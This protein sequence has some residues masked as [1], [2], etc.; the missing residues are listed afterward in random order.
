MVANLVSS[1]ETFL[2]HGTFSSNPGGF[3]VIINGITIHTEKVEIMLSF[4]KE[5]CIKRM[6]GLT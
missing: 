6:N 4:R 2:K 5:V 1:V 3:S